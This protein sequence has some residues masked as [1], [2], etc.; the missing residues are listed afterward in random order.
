M[1]DMIQIGC[2][3]HFKGARTLLIAA[4]RDS[5]QHVYDVLAAHFEAPVD[6]LA[7]LRRL[8]GTTRLLNIERLDFIP[9]ASTTHLRMSGRHVTWQFTDLYCE[10]LKGLLDALK[11][12][13]LPAH[14]Y[15]DTGSADAQFLISKDEYVE[16]L[17]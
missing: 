11:A 10:R 16:P 5:F 6:V 8:D 1:T 7:A 4:T 13:D 12:S 9:H 15:L 2:L 3:E 14:Q 17:G